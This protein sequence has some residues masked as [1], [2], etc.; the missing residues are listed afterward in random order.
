MCCPEQ[1]PLIEKEH[2]VNKGNNNF[3]TKEF[4][5][6]KQTGSLPNQTYGYQGKNMGRGGIN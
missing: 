2:I 3:S 1:D 5:K 6:L 4:T